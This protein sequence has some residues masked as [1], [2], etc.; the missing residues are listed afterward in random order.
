M[1][2]IL[3]FQVTCI[4]IKM[5]VLHA[6]VEFVNRMERY[7]ETESLSSPISFSRDSH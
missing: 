2:R 7:M 5:K 6:L 3:T 1:T 4:G